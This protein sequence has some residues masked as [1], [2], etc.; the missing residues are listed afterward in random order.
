MSDTESDRSPEA[1]HLS[2]NST[3]SERYVG[4]Q[5]T[6]YAEFQIGTAA[7]MAEASA[8]LFQTFIAPGDSVIDF[9]C[10]DGSILTALTCGKK[11]G[12]EPNSAA[13]SRSQRNGIETYPSV[14]DIPRGQVDVVISHHALEHCL[15]PVDEL[16]A[17][18]ST[19]RPGGLLVLVV[20][21]DDWRTQRKYSPDDVNHHLFTWTPALLGNLIVEGGL[22]VEHIEVLTHAWPPNAAFW[23][24][25]VPHGVFDALS[26]LTSALARRRQIRAI[27]HRSD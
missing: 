20:P 19:L 21:L 5:G 25:A 4:I 9:G 26:V 13:R 2:T 14:A 17:L 22:E 10:G 3:V 7:P 1:A 18:N 11:V 27:A 24:R 8:R 6:E 23:W 12:V 15:R 16:R